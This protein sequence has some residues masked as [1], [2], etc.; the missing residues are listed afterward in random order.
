MTGA[1][2]YLRSGAASQLVKEQVLKAAAQALQGKLELGDVRLAGTHV[3]LTDLKLFTPEG[4]LVAH[5]ERAEATMGVWALTSGEVRLDD[6]QL[7]G[8]HVYLASDERGLNLSR[9]MAS[10]TPAAPAALE[11]PGE[12]TRVTVKSLA[13]R[14]GTFGF[15]TG[16]QAPMLLDF[17]E[18]TADGQ[19]TVLTSPLQLEGALKLQG[20][21]KRPVDGP[22]RIDVAMRSHASHPTQVDVALTLGDSQLKARV[23]LPEPDVA[24]ETLEVSAALRAGLG[25][26]LE[27]DE[28]W[29]VKGDVSLKRAALTAHALGAQATLN[30]T[31]ETAPLQVD[32]FELKVADFSPR[33]L[34]PTL[35]SSKVALEVKGTLREAGG[36]LLNGNA[37]AKVKWTSE[38]GAPWADVDAKATA[39]GGALDVSQLTARVFGAT[40]ETTGKADLRTVSLKGTVVVP[41]VAQL[42]RGLT[43]ALGVEPLGVTGS[44]RL[45]VGVDGPWKSAQFKGRGRF[46][47]LGVSSV[48][49][50]GLAVDARVP[51]WAR[52]Y[53]AGAELTVARV[54][55]GEQHL[56]AVD[57]KV[58]TWGRKLKGSFTARGLSQIALGVTGT[59]APGGEGMTVSE[60]TLSYPEA[61]WSLLAPV[62][63]TWSDGRFFSGQL[64]LV[65]GAQRL[66]WVGG[67]SRHGVDGEARVEGFNLARLPALAPVSRLKLKGLL[68]VKAKVKGPA[69]AFRVDAQA[70]WKDGAVY[71]IENVALQSNVGFQ[72]GELKGVL[73]LKTSV[74]DL[75][76]TCD[77]P[78]EAWSKGSPAPLSLELKM[79]DVATDKVLALTG[80]TL[81]LRGA[82]TGALAVTGDT[83]APHV[84]LDV[85]GN[86]LEVLP[87][88]EMA[89]LAVR[90][91]VVTAKSDERAQADVQV[92]LQLLGGGAK[93]S[94]HTDGVGKRLRDGMPSAETWK[95]MPV[96]VAF[97]IDG[98]EAEQALQA[99]GQS[100][101]WA[102]VLSAR[103]KVVGS[104]SQPLVDASAKWAGMKNESLQPHDVVLSLST[105][106][107]R[108]ALS[109]T[110]THDHQTAGTVDVVLDAGADKWADIDALA[111]ATFKIDAHVGPLSL[112]QT[113]E[114]ANGRTKT[115]LTQGLIRLTVAG[116]GTLA[117]PQLKVRAAVEAPSAGKVSLGQWNAAWDYAAKKHEVSW[118][119]F[120]P[121]GG[122][123]KVKGQA[124]LEVG[125]KAVQ[126][127]LAVQS[128]PFDV[129]LEAKAFDL[130]F[131]SGVHERLRAVGGILEGKGVARGTAKEPFMEADLS[132]TK[133]VLSM[134]GV[135]DY[136]DV[137]A[138]VHVD[139]SRITVQ[140]LKVSSGTGWAQLSGEG[141]RVKPAHWTVKASGE[142]KEFP[143]V[144]DEQ[145]V[146]AA[147][148]Q[149]RVDGEFAEGWLDLRDVSVAKARIDLPTT[150]RKDLQQLE[151]REDIYIVRRGQNVAQVKRERALQKSAP[152]AFKLRLLAKVPDGIQVRG[153]DVHIDADLSDNFRVEYANEARIFGTIAIRKGYADVLGRRFNVSGDSRITFAGEAS[154]PFLNV[155]AE[156]V[157]EREQVT[158]FVMVKGQGVEQIS[159]KTRSQPPLP[160]SEIYTL[161][162]TGRRNLKPGSGAS[163]TGDQAASSVAGVLAGVLKSALM[164]K[165]P[166]QIDVLTI[167]SGEKGFGDWRVEA[168]KYI[169]DNLYVGALYQAGADPR[170]GQN[171]L[172][173]KL[174]YQWTKFISVEAFGGSERAAGAELVWSYE[175]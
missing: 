102:G 80:S 69:K 101:K 16:N 136:R 135:G 14:Q 30:A 96:T 168:G 55:I 156:W 151:H 31:Y 161:L 89:P 141:L 113:L 154:K 15:K 153:T 43:Q 48:K 108:S 152:A 54:D 33:R 132:L 32:V 114:M 99:L 164:S 52:P 133:G 41:S 112:P 49:V 70:R 88:P 13:L 27:G 90:R 117:A 121:Q 73:G 97:S 94:V 169:N 64:T 145:V 81:G 125:L 157:N 172:T 170:R 123:L 68:D 95:A 25:I 4:E 57:A 19:A 78:L 126:K 85:E 109:V 104:L 20:H 37:T 5:I 91:A 36:S 105:Q 120:S 21:A 50:T 129:T 116:S 98:I 8:P 134:A 173:A 28:K 66:S 137:S 165:L 149:L 162:A 127:G 26:A 140:T 53:E 100:G 46:E 103:G 6:V 45:D 9:A 60:V 75:D 44:G 39:K 86:A 84:T 83:Q 38:S 82:L 148:A 87:S 76:A 74:G 155:T 35:P 17:N 111:D 65:A 72:N 110:L 119:M 24:V 67:W 144:T 1:L 18:L 11:K 124:Q 3:T 7:F 115:W 61:Q 22:L 62:D 47:S 146:A 107:Q 175:Y 42:G 56:D 10:K 40:L 23:G 163:M 160:E 142:V 138:Q 150:K 71:G 166:I 93:L 122:S 171:T 2:I 147:S 167:D 58:S 128:A 158:V 106:R 63:M 12:G 51:N 118:V 79:K 130:A 143:L 59:L 29:T 77:F 34:V 139:P 131:L 174:E 159:L 92:D